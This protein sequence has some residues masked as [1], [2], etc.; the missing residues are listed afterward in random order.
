MIILIFELI[1]HLTISSPDWLFLA[2]G[3]GGNFFGGFGFGLG[4]GLELAEGRG[5]SIGG[6]SF[7]KNDRVIYINV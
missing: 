4:L 3:F 6:G 2:I 1:K 5:W 7:V